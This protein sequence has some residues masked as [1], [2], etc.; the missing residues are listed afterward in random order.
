MNERLKDLY[1]T[2]ILNHHR[3]PVRYE[4]RQ[5]AGQQLEAY[6]PLCG[7]KFRLFFE[8]EDERITAI[9]FHGHGCAI[10]RASTSVLVETL[11]GKT[12]EEAKALCAEFM[13][14]VAP[15]GEPA[16]PRREIFEAFSAA[17]EFPGRLKCATLAWDELIAFLDARDEK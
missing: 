7:D 13:Q 14:Y 4:E 8:L 15:D 1:K 5:E 2:V 3:H 9:Y 11:N 17:R 6:N 12:V 10:S 16:G